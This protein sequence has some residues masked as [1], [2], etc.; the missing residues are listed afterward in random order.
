MKKSLTELQAVKRIDTN[1]LKNKNFYS[2]SFPTIAGSGPNG[3]I[4]HYLRDPK[5]KP[6]H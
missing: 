4:V 6:Y 2:L 1:R 5:N 3:A